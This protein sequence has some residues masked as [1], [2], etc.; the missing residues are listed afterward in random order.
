M[1]L[2]PFPSPFCI[3]ISFPSFSL[4]ILFPL[5]LYSLSSPA[6]LFPFLPPPL[7]FIFFFS[8]FPLYP[9]PTYSSPRLFPFSL[10]LYPSPL[11][12]SSPRL[13]TSRFRQNDLA[14]IVSR[15]HQVCQTHPLP[16][17]VHRLMPFFVR[18]QKALSVQS[19]RLFCVENVYFEESALL[20]ESVYSEIFFS[21]FFIVISWVEFLAFLISELSYVYF[22][23][24]MYILR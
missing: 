12:P 24:E 15:R 23:N 6:S 9:S 3:F 4:F 5:P 22:K 14:N 18:G 19:S 2:Y 16:L 13:F 10:P 7:L 21:H 11:S 8:P 1:P 17:I 20:E